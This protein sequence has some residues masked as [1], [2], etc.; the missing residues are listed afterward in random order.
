MNTSHNGIL[1]QL[2]RMTG[3]AITEVCTRYCKHTVS[4]ADATVAI[5]CDR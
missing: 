5:V 3:C 4:D 2:C 1:T